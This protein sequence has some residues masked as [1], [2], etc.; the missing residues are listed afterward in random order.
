MPPGRPRS[1]PGARYRH[2]RAPFAGAASRPTLAGDR[3]GLDHA[4]RLAACPAGVAWQAE[5]VRVVFDAELWLW[6][7][8]RADAWT[9]VALP[10]EESAE[11]GD[12]AGGLRR[13]FG[14]LRVRATIGTST[15]TT[16]RPVLARI[17][18]MRQELK[19]ALQARWDDSLKA[20][21]ALA[22]CSLVPTLDR[23]LAPLRDLP[24]E[25]G[26]NLASQIPPIDRPGTAPRVA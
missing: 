7:A 9:F 15:W 21:A 20:R 24:L 12:L 22:P 25:G 16:S 8:R 3:R 14:S 26:R 5:P 13:G 18:R 23:L 4:G 6:D 10:A 1:Q 19:D 17:E 2:H 11:I